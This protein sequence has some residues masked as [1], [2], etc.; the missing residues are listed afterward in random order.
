M[1]KQILI[2]II[3]ALLIKLFY[4]GFAIVVY[5]Y[6]DNRGFKPDYEG[7]IS[8]LKKNDAYWYTKIAINGYP[9]IENR[10]DLGYHDGKD[11]KQSVWAFFPAYPLTVR[12]FSKIPGIDL[13][14]AFLLVSVLSSVLGFIA[15]YL[16]LKVYLNDKEKALFYTIVLMTLPFHFYFSMFYTEALFFFM[17][18]SSFLAVF[19]KK[20]LIMSL[21]LIPLTLIRPN[22][23]ILIMPLYLF[24]LENENLL[25][26]YKFDW[27]GIFNKR[28]I[29]HSLYFLTGPIV[30]VIYGFYQQYMTN[31]FFA[32]SIAQQGWYRDFMFPLLS[33]FR[34]GDPAIQFNSVYTIF[35][36]LVAA[37]SWKKF[38]LS[39]NM[40]IWI[41]LLL[42]LTSGSV[43]SMQRFII[44]I[45]PITMIFGGWLYKSNYRYAAVTGLFLLQLATYYFWLTGHPISY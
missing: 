29:N 28:N 27:K 2:I 43:M 33:F 36:I 41:N 13:N 19:K 15:F 30:F 3:A 45:F 9:K 1:K 10:D 31:E 20:Y 44:V 24:M 21:V 8:T 12:L 16:F 23:I 4:F 25:K 5:Q 6:S 40:L 32:F 39:L 38:P 26:K 11:F 18:I 42:P 7:F 37:F 22:G 14:T 17:M 34:Q 35:I